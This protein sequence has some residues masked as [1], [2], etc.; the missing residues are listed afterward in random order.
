MKKWMIGFV[1]GIAITLGLVI[2]DGHRGTPSLSV[3]YKVVTIDGTLIW[4]CPRFTLVIPE[5]EL[6]DAG[7]GT[8]M[9]AGKNQGIFEFGGG[10]LNWSGDHAG[11]TRAYSYDRGMGIGVLFVGGRVVL[12][13]EDATRL[14]VVG[15]GMDIANRN[16]VVILRKNEPPQ[17][18]DMPL[19]Q[20]LSEDIDATAREWI[21]SDFE[22]NPFVATLGNGMMQ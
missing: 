10:G 21:L 13:E 18:L 19:H 14:R 4:R 1:C 9:I 11:L 17:V 8:I 16:P 5:A 15:H 3:P 20:V 2:L 22:T 7:G 12:I 6:E